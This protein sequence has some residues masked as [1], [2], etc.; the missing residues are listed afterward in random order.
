[1]LIFCCPLQVNDEYMKML[2]ILSRKIKFIGVDPMVN[3][4]I[5][6]KDVQPELERL[7]QKAVAK[8]NLRIYAHSHLTSFSRFLVL[9]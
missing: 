1:M 5:A 4:S 2:E 7:R 6:L 9:L 8:V 3:S